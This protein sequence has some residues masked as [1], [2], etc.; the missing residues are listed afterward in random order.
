MARIRPAWRAMTAEEPA[1]RARLAMFREA[2]P[3][4]SVRE[5]AGYWQAAIPEPRGETIITR[6]SLP[7]LLGKLDEIFPPGT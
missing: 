6:Y 2:H 1:E 3:E 7:E 4:V 5:G